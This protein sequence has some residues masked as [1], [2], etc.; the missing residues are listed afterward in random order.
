LRV[1]TVAALNLQ[2]QPF[3]RVIA[4]ANLEIRLREQ[5]NLSRSGTTAYLKNTIVE[6]AL[7]AEP[8]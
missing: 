8:G 7:S 2:I 4:G 1:E 5:E 3:V 6:I